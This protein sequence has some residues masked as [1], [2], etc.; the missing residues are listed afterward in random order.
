MADRGMGEWAPLPE[1]LG[2]EARALAEY[3]RLL[4]E[5]TG[6]SLAALAERTHYSKSSWQRCLNGRQIPPR[7]ALR[8]LAAAAE[9]DPARLLGL[10]EAVLRSGRLPPAPP[11]LRRPA[12]QRPHPLA[13]RPPVDRPPVD[14]PPV[15]RSPV[16]RSP[17]DRSPVD[18]S[19]VDRPTQGRLP[20]D[21]VPVL[22][23]SPEGV[24]TRRREQRD[25]EEFPAPAAP[26][27]SHAATVRRW[28]LVA[29]GLLVLLVAV[30]AVSAVLLSRQDT[31]CA[32]VTTRP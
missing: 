25:G 16:D 24:L 13:D 3:C 21:V 14:R 10:R 20:E 9:A 32:T 26:V 30:T 6:L 15:D 12:G 5:R 27:A 2:R 23:P 18:R 22:S 4:K 29:A 11:Q 17:V 1:D 19:P 28:R 31:G 8:S 7:S